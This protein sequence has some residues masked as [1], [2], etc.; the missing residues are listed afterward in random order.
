MG[1]KMVEASEKASGRT[2]GNAKAHAA[3]ISDDLTA[4][5]RKRLPEG[6]KYVDVYQL[7]VFLCQDL[8]AACHR[9]LEAVDFHLARLAAIREAREQRDAAKS[10]LRP[11]LFSVR[12]LIQ[13]L[14]GEVGVYMLFNDA[15]EIPEDPYSLRRLARNVVADLRDP[16]LQLPPPRLEGVTISRRTLAKGIEKPLTQLSDALDEIEDVAPLASQSLEAKHRAHK[17][18]DTLN[19]RAARFLEAFYVLAGHDIL[20]A[21]VRP[22]SHRAKKLAAAAAGEQGA[23]AEGTP[24]GARSSPAKTPAANPAANAAPGPGEPAARTVLPWAG[25][26]P[27]P[28]PAEPAASPPPAG[29]AGAAPEASRPSPRVEAKSRPA[30]PATDSG[31]APGGKASG[32]KAPGGKGDPPTS[33]RS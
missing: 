3:R 30:E 22:S 20:A 13:D 24:S 33:G 11:L 21:K 12:N 9:L 15:T 18:L 26:R 6:Q 5:W 10:V 8:R 28:P 16:K 32:G 23:A 27:V 4:R 1:Y 19:A 17:A 25:P 2:A 14:H 29:K 31:A 7:Q